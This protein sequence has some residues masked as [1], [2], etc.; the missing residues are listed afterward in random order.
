MSFSVFVRE[1]LGYFLRKGT[2]CRLCFERSREMS[3]DVP[4]I[5]FLRFL[6]FWEFDSSKFVIFLRLINFSSIFFDFLK[7]FLRFSLILYEFLLF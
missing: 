5:K 7:L 3:N 2:I 1:D 4:H 6:S